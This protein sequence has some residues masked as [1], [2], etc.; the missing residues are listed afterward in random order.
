MYRN[1]CLARFGRLK[2]LSCDLRSTGQCLQQYSLG[3]CHLNRKQLAG[4]DPSLAEYQDQSSRLASSTVP[5]VR[6]FACGQALA[7]DVAFSS[8]QW[9][10][11]SRLHGFPN[12]NLN[13]SCERCIKVIKRHVFRIQVH[14]HVFEQPLHLLAGECALCQIIYSELALPRT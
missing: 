8:R 11:G 12:K 9:T 6:S 4:R 7:E 2:L 1:V 14:V 3:Q 5:Q 13:L 10:T